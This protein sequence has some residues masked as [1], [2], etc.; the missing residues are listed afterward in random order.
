MNVLC[1][2]YHA[3]M[4]Y[5]LFSI[6]SCIFDP[7]HQIDAAEKAIYRLSHTA[8]VAQRGFNSVM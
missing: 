4:L 6:V 7:S 5:S 3:K 8:D 2:Y 1:V